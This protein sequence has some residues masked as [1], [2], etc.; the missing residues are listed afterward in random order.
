MFEH[1]VLFREFAFETLF[2]FRFIEN[3]NGRCSF[4]FSRYDKNLFII[5]IPVLIF[6]GNERVINF[7]KISID[8]YTFLTNNDQH[9]FSQKSSS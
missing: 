9:Y 2:F 1:D 5:L 3:A 7:I 6:S 8:S 4:Y